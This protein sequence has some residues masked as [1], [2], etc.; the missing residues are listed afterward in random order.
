[1]EKM[2]P[3]WKGKDFIEED[4]DYKKWKE[5]EIKWIRIFK[6]FNIY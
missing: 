2:N 6:K 3:W 5:N 4:E 1:M